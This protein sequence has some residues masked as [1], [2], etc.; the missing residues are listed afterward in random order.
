MAKAGPILQGFGEGAK[1][2]SALQGSV[3]RSS[4]PAGDDT[5]TDGEIVEVTVT[6][7]EG[8]VSNPIG[9]EMLGAIL[10]GQMNPTS[11]SNVGWSTSSGNLIVR[12]DDD[13]YAFWVF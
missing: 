11:G 13:T 12:G 3:S 5:I 1:A 10:I 2:I 8:V 6:S 9:R 4:R 7:N